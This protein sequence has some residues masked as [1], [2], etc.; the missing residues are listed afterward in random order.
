MKLTLSRVLRCCYPVAFLFLFT[1]G[2]SYQTS[3]S[4]PRPVDGT[5]AIIK[6]FDKHP[7][8]A[9][10]DLHG[11]QELYDFIT[12]LVRNPDFL[13]KVN[14]IVVEFGNAL[15]QDVTDR[16]VS[17]K[18][19]PLAEV[20]QIWRNHTNPIVFDSPVIEQFFKTIH[21]VNQTLPEGKRLRILA[22]DPPID[23]S[24]TQTNKDFGRM[25]F[26]RDSHFAEV[27]EK[28][29]LAKGR[30]A[31]FIIGAAHLVRRL[32]KNNVT[33]RI[34]SQ[35][36]QSMFIVVP[37]GG[38]WERNEELEP[39]FTS[40]KVGSLALLKGTWLGSLH[41]R[42]KWPQMKNSR[43]SDST[44]EPRLEDVADAWLYVGPR[45]LLTE[46]LPFPGIYRDEY[47]NELNRRHMIMWGKP[48]DDPTADNFNTSARY[49][50]KPR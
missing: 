23:W 41:P 14:D 24:K 9:I 4:D 13:N 26:K 3:T 33:G 39:R 49:Y 30:K 11:C 32:D 45:D 48:I 44:A 22:G 46:A 1:T 5:E 6:A 38:F 28:E 34:E 21:E 36:P 29:V 37:H 20:R 31:L 19:V 17:G 50:V 16:Y 18:E 25:L 47:W 43:L 27:V 10:G 8:V 40:W 12:P 42:L 2:Q 15:Y 35:R 7:I